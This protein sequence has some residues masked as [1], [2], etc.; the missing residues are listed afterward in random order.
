MTLEEIKKLSK[1]S[2]GYSVICSCSHT[3]LIPTF[4]STKVCNYCG[5]T[6]INFR[7]KPKLDGSEKDKT[8]FKKLVRA[9][10][11]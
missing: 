2:L 5:N 4:L 11:K 3:N 10:V 8:E 7:Y 9:L 6:I 1:K